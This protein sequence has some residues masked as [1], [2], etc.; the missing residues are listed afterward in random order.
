MS[1][2]SAL[3]YSRHCEVDEGANFL[4]VFDKILGGGRV[5]QAGAGADGDLAQVQGGASA[6]ARPRPSIALRR[7]RRAKRLNIMYKYATSV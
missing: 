7:Q 2:T 3:R 1:F 4:A 5:H 6:A